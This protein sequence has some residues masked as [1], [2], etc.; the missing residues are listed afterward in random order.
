MSAS[1]PSIPTDEHWIQKLLMIGTADEALYRAKSRG[2]NMVVG[3]D[4]TD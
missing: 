4:D 2:R 3:A 1:R